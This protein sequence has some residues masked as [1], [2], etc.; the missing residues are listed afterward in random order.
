[1]IKMLEKNFKHML[2]ISKKYDKLRFNSWSKKRIREGN[3]F[4]T[5]RKHLYDDKRV[6]FAIPLPWKIIKTYFWIIEGAK[7]PEELQKVINQI[8]RRKV[9]DDEIFYFHVGDFR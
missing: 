9:E 3:K 6:L 2:I 1:M 7:N 5:S 4:A 8:H